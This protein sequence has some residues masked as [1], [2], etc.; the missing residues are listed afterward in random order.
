MP[1]THIVEIGDTLYK[2]ARQYNITLESLIKLNNLSSDLI[3]PG[4]VLI[5]SNDPDTEAASPEP[6]NEPEQNPPLNTTGLQI[7]SIEGGYLLP[8]RDY[9]Q[10]ELDD[11]TLLARLVYSEAG[12]EPYEGQVAVAAVLLNRVKSPLFPNSIREAVYQPYQFE[13]VANGRI[14]QVPSNSACN[15]ALGAI[16]GEDPS[17]GALFFWNPYKVRKTNWVWTRKITKQIGNHVFA[18]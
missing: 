2:I 5:I 10:Q 13:P 17:G 16:A 1:A 9:T 6:V 18:E 12:G 11:I 7:P 4:D 8:E 3:H 15:A 14:N